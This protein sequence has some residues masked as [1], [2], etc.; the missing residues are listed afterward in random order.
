MARTGVYVSP[1]T[2]ATIA[3]EPLVETEDDVDE[4]WDVPSDDGPVS[5]SD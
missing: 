4:G 1:V 2:E 3:K 5:L